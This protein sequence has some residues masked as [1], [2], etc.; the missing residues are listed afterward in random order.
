[1]S[2]R[3]PALL[4]IALVIALAGGVVTAVSATAP[5][6]GSVELNSTVLTPGQ[7]VRITGTGG[8][9]GTGVTATL[10]G[11]TA[12]TPSTD[13]AST[14]SVN[15]VSGSGGELL[16]WMVATLPP[17]PCPCVVRV[18]DNT[19]DYQQKIPV[20]VVGAATAPVPPPTTAPHPDFEITD[21]QVI[22]GITLSSAFGGSADR[23]LKFRLV[24][25]G[26]LPW[27]PLVLG[28]WGK[29][30]KT[31]NVINMPPV[32]AVG[33][34]Q[35]TEV[36][37]EFSLPALSVGHYTVKVMVQVVGF[38]GESTAKVSTSTWPFGLL[39]VA[40][41][42]LELIVMGITRKVRRRRRARAAARQ[43]APGGSPSEFQ[44]GLVTLGATI[45]AT[46]AT[47]AAEGPVDP[48]PPSGP[49]G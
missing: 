36:V 34:G 12:V 42:L 30:S 7:R 16:G 18:T 38:Q 41:I 45:E 32:G 10:C 1:M 27:T 48:A 8:G 47:K 15:M 3:W 35:S 31:T 25:P 17:T 4:A 40:L 49:P 43:T 19:G 13:C 14:T 5:H 39:I 6:G 23:T 24:N 46:Q 37:A 33:A 2:R 29:G 44:G 11:A 9:A 28:R 26:P 21:M 20:Q 22:G